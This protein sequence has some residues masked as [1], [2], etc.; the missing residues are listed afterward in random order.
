MSNQYGL[1]QI[2]ADSSLKLCYDMNDA[3]CYPGSGNIIYESQS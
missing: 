2:V 3:N 1:A